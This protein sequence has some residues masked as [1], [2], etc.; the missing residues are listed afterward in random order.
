VIPGITPGPDLE[1]T[2]GMAKLLHQLQNEEKPDNGEPDLAEL[3][4]DPDVAA[5]VARARQ[6]EKN[7]PRKHHIVPGSYLRRWTEGRQLRV[8]EIDEHKTWITTAEKAARRTD[9]YSLASD[10]LEPDQLPPLLAETMLS[11]IESL[12]KVSID[13]LLSEGIQ[14]LSRE[15]RSNLAI[16]LGFQFM[17]GESTRAMIRKITNDAVKL[18]YGRLKKPGIQR[19]L[20]E[21]GLADTPER[22][23]SVAEFIRDLNDGTVTVGPQNAAEVM[24]AFQAA[25]RVAEILYERPWEV[26]KTPPI[27]VTSDEPVVPI[28]RLGQDRK[29]RAGLSDARLV[30][31]PLSPAHLLVIFRH[32]R[33]IHT[34][35][36]LTL[37]EIAEVNHEILANATRWAFERPNRR[38]SLALRVP[39][40]PAATEVVEHQI[41]GKANTSMIR[42]FRHSRWAR[43]SHPPPWPLQRWP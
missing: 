34:V 26:F 19:M 2:P 38:T 29:E 14:G 20:K 5:L 33:P 11:D 36:P 13:A 23:E 21:R 8:T 31:F 39:P 40:L 43:A 3:R 16:F 41:A 28:G 15:D 10:D 24:Q 25:T 32:S 22:I 27:L 1:Y 17:R 35:S 4:D 18:E 9:Y 6:N 7:P 42:L 30:V 37:S 12:G